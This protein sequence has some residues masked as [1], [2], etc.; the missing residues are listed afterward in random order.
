MDSLCYFKSDNVNCPCKIIK[1]NYEYCD[2]INFLGDL[3][4]SGEQDR[5]D[6]FLENTCSLLK[7]Q[8]LYERKLS[9]QGREQEKEFLDG[10]EEGDIVYC[11]TE[12]EDV[13][14]LEKS[15]KKFSKCKYK[16][17][18]GEIKEQWGFCFRNISKGDKYIEYKV[19]NEKKLNGYRDLARHHGFRVE[20]IKLENSHLLKI[21]GDTQE[22]LNEFL[23][24]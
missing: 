7:N 1:G 11:I 16:I 17:L 3:L 20:V 19:K 23:F 14:F 15:D 8:W 13:I 4:L 5:I 18:D 21:F 22:E 2:F 24:K 9:R 10:V 6:Q 12:M